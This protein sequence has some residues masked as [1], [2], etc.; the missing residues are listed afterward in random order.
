MK[1]FMPC[2]LIRH[3][4]MQSCLTSANDE[5]LTHKKNGKDNG[6]EP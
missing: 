5:A 4:C 6:A 1:T 3:A 2:N